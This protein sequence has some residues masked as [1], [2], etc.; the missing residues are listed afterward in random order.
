MEQKQHTCSRFV[1]LRSR[2]GFTIVEVVIALAVFSIFVV[3]AMRL[4]LM[5]DEASGSGRDHYIAANIG[6]NRIERC[7][8]FDI[9]QIWSF[10]ESD[11]LVDVNGQP[12]TEGNYRRTTIISDAAPTNVMKIIVEVEI[13]DRDTWGFDGAVETV[14]TYLTEMKGPPNRE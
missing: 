10:E 3:G 6:K 2:A 9:E 4:L 14:A 8:A 13:R 7:R 1:R 12:T 5:A 11:T